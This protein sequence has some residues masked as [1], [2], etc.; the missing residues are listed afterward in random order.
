[1]YRLFTGLSAGLSDNACTLDMNCDSQFRHLHQRANGGHWGEHE[2]IQLISLG[3]NNYA[4]K[5]NSISFP[6]FSDVPGAENRSN[7]RLNWFQRH[8]S[9]LKGRSSPR[10]RGW[11]FG[12]YVGLYASVAVFLSN[13]ALLPTTI[14]AQDGAIDGIGTTAKGDMG[15]STRLSTTYHVL[16]NILSTILLTSSNYAMQIIC[17]PTRHEVNQAH[18][19]EHWLEIGIMSLHNLRRIDRKQVLLWAI[20]AFTS[21]SL[22]LL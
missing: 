21:A 16:I 2:A 4:P 10:I 13:V 7:G 3:P 19:N 17:A 9:I 6:R 8:L 22:H 18:T 1:M 15:K 5:E 12:L 20:L 14:F 11:K